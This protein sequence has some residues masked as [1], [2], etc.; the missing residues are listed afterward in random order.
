MEIMLL[1]TGTSS[2]LTLLPLD[3]KDQT[4]VAII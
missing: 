3:K 2:K 1:G 4:K